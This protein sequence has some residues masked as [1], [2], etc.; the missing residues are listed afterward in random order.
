M[1]DINDIGLYL[2][3]KFNIRT[4]NKHS[5]IQK[6]IHEENITR[7]FAIFFKKVYGKEKFNKKILK[8]PKSQNFSNLSITLDIISK[9]SWKLFE[10]EL[11]LDA[12]ILHHTY[13]L[14]IPPTAIE[15]F[16]FNNLCDKKSFLYYDTYEHKCKSI[17]LNDDL[18]SQLLYYK[19]IKQKRWI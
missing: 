18:Y 16:T 17:I 4:Q 10:N 12:I 6:T 1:T 9:A 5:D 7:L 15:T 8:L 14:S 2:N 11:Y 3:S 19:K 13:S